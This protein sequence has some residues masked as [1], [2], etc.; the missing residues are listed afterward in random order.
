MNEDKRKKYNDE[1]RTKTYRKKN[2]TLNYVIL[3]L[4]VFLFVILLFIFHIRMN[5]N[6]KI[7]SI[8]DYI[9]A[10][11][12]EVLGNLVGVLASFLIFDVIHN[13]ITKDAYAA[14]ASQ[15]IFDTLMYHPD[16]M[17]LYDD[18][19]KKEF[20]KSFIRSTADSKTAA[21]MII[22]RFEAY[23]RTKEDFKNN[24]N[25]GENECRIRTSFNYDFKLDRERSMAFSEL[26]AEKE[27]DPYFYVQ[28][29]LS[30]HVEY[31]HEKGNNLDSKY[32]KI[33]LIYDN[34]LLDRFLRGDNRSNDKGNGSN[35]IREELS[36]MIFRE[37]LDIEQVD[38]E[39]FA[40][41]S[42]HPEELKKLVESMFRPVVSIDG[43]RGD[44]IGVELGVAEKEP[45]G[46]IVT[47]EVSHDITANE[48]D[49]NVIFHMPKRYGSVLEVALVEP[50]KDPKVSLS[51][52]EDFM[53]IEVFSFLNV[54]ES[55]AVENTLEDN[56]GV[57]QV[58]IQDEWVCPIS[59]IV[60]LVKKK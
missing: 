42:N 30:Y 12:D 36:N 54:G 26:K 19:H 55:S 25:I 60:F 14:E 37:N 38:K 11:G 41:L 57:F 21:D 47:Y 24:S 4:I 52:N 27:N 49:I 8:K 58:D 53:N 2:I 1:L 20:V 16:A 46:L 48:H 22:N 39:Q 31:L 15:Q 5:P 59:G 17:K 44:L 33:G 18:E 56:N 34:A 51:Y 40:V 3:Y 43:K 32:V 6:N 9:T 50:T 13:K 35:K 28:E 45:F 23:L 10:F 29:M 7:D